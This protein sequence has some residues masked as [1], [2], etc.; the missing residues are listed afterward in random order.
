MRSK[1]SPRWRGSLATAKQSAG[2]SDI[3]DV[4]Q[5]LGV[6]YLMG[7]KRF[8]SLPADMQKVIADA[9]RI[10]ADT[11]TELY[12]DFDA[13]SLEILKTNHGMQ[14]NTVDKVAFRARMQPVFD[15]FQDR[16]GKDLIETARRMG[17]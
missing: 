11:E 5:K 4:R 12:N 1:G 2:V 9:A 10:G 3:S 6:I 16:V 13:K 14:I 7:M 8:Q 17:T 15:R